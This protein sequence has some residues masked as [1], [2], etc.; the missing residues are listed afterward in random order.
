MAGTPAQ[1]P[2]API[3]ASLACS[4]IFIAR[5]SFV[6]DGR[7]WYSLFDDAMISMRYARNLAS[8]H[9]LVWNAGQPA[10]EGYTNFLWTLWMALLH[11]LPIP[12][13]AISLAVMISGAAIV[14][15][16][17]AVVHRIAARLAPD[18][19]RAAYIAAWLTA[20]YYPLTYWTLRGMEVG[21][22]TLTLAVGTLLALRL[23]ARWSARDLAALVLLM[24]AGILT[25]P[26]V[27]APCVV[28]AAFVVW[29]AAPEHRR[30]AAVALVGAIGG[31]F[32]AH[33]AFRVWYYGH[34]LPNTYYLKVV[35][36]PLA[37]RIGRGLRG[38]AAVV[39]LH[40]L[41]PA[42]LAGVVAFRRRE[43]KAIERGLFL[44]VALF[45]VACAYSV[46][47]GGDAW[48]LMLYANRYVTPTVP[49]LLILAALAVDDLTRA[50]HSPSSR[51][52]LFAAALFVVAAA[53]T[54]V[55]PAATQGLEPM[56]ADLTM[57][58][59]RVAL[60]AAPVLILPLAARAG[61]TAASVL[62]LSTIVAVNGLACAQWIGHNAFYAADD[63]WTTRYGLALRAATKEDATIAVTWAGEIPY[64]SHR[65]AIDLLGKSD[66]VVATAPRQSSV[67]F[68]PGHDKW[69]YDYS[70]GELRPDVVAQLWRATDAD[71]AAIERS[72]Y[73]PLGPWTFVRADSAR[74]DAT[75]LRRTTCDMLR[76]DPFVL[77]SA[78]LVPPDQPAL[79]ARYCRE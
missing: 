64:F 77:G 68:E 14:A 21:L 63:A 43:G 41:V 51:S 49:G 13:R 22:V 35:G 33:T 44:L 4:A 75:M 25:R 5:T 66:R 58:I 78:T 24:A 18:A 23:S 27:V 9:G 36:A 42:T 50:T 69:N 59:V 16:A 47:V 6:V 52:A 8:G 15:G 31:T 70:V 38:L 60:T 32:A 26:D 67:G 53:L 10:V 57:R 54:A 73:R 11:L 2:R 46:Y 76:E 20:C 29:T 12:E 28:I 1:S 19:P 71:R 55:A 65:T 45:V 37:V 56:R 79:V 62:T 40:L 48:E 34:P 39:A 30:T 72:G 7:R 61:R 3:V 17:V 74:V